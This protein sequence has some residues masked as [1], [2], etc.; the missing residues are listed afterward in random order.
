V[1][2]GNCG[3]YEMDARIEH[4]NKECN[5][6]IGFY[7]HLCGD[8]YTASSFAIWLAAG[9]IERQQVPKVIIPFHVIRQPIEHILIVNHYQ[10]KQ[11]SF[12]LVSKHE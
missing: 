6:P 9:I 12:L 3:D 1:L 5:R 7:K 10:D 4:F 2:S 11:Y 8:Y